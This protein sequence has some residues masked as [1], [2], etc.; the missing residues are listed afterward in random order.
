[1]RKFKF[2]W[3]CEFCDKL[4]EMIIPAETPQEALHKFVASFVETPHTDV[5]FQ[6]PLMG[7]VEE[8]SNGAES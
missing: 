6:L 4:H 2:S 7:M 5:F 3:L 8:V 1:M